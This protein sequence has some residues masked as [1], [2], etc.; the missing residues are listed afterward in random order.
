V[1]STSKPL[2]T[3][4]R[5]EGIVT[6]SSRTTIINSLVP[7][8]FVDDIRRSVAFY[9][10]LLGFELSGTW[11]PDGELSWC[12]LRRG[13]SAIM[14]QQ[15]CDEDG[16]AKG[17]GRGVGFFFHCDDADAMHDELSSRGLKLDPPCIAFYGMNQVFVTDPDGYELCFQ[18]ETSR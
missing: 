17:R 2:G 11:E 7:L 9:R 13:G 8:L 4:L 3:R 1:F 10:D 18:N 14:L 5:R 16:P 6:Q 15:A 12:R